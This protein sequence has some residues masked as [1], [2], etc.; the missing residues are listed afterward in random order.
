[1]KKKLVFA[2]ICFVLISLS[3]I[4]QIM[5]NSS[6]KVGIGSSPDFY[7]NM[8]IAPQ[9]SSPGSTNFIIG[10]WWNNT[11]GLISIGVH[12]SYSWIQSWHTKPLHI[13]RVGNH[14]IFGSESV[15][16]VGIGY[17][18]TTPSAKLH[19]IGNIYATGTITSSDK[20]LKKDITEL[21]LK[22]WDYNN[23]KSVTYKLDINNRGFTMEG[24]DTSK[25]AKI[26]KE[27]FK[28]EHVGFLAQ[29]VQEIFPDFVYEDEEGYL[30]IDYQSFIPILFEIVKNQQITIETLNDELQ[31]VVNNCCSNL[32]SASLLGTELP[33]DQN[34]KL[35][36]NT[37]NPFSDKTQI[38]YYITE[39]DIN[40]SIFVYDMNGSQ[41]RKFELQQKGDGSIVISGNEL[42]AGMY[43][44]SLIA[45]GQ[46]IDTKRMVLTD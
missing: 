26:D 45:N 10:N 33:E 3:G 43:L 27:F 14:V 12:D 41:L 42:K 7:A 36:Q 5:V 28:R 19:V 32:K 44:Y 21:D 9:Y 35:Y 25:V 6:G 40:A 15:E 34:T 31:T 11:K 22:K 23:L 39:H 1:M 24:L 38:R 8:N 37:P 30:S 2:T 20:R 17:G 29:E 16:S 18:M 13:N 46:V 4:A